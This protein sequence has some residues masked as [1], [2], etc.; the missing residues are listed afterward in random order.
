MYKLFNFWF[1]FVI[2]WFQKFLKVRKSQ[3]N[4]KNYQQNKN[5]IVEKKRKQREADPVGTK[6]YQAE[7][8]QKN[9]ERLNE[10]RKELRQNPTPTG[11][12]LREDKK[13]QKEEELERKREG[14]FTSK[15]NKFYDFISFQK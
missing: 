2:F 13:K 15:Q 5:E 8:F 12:K 4:K 10:Y 1:N 3:R 9:K 6:K 11:L 7:Y 14:L